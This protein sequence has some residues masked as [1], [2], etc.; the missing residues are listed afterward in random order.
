M[1]IIREGFC[2]HHREARRRAG[3]GGERF[4]V[5]SCKTLRADFAQ[6]CRGRRSCEGENAADDRCREFVLVAHAFLGKD[7]F[8]SKLYS[9][10]SMRRN[11]RF[12]YCRTGF[13][14]GGHAAYQDR[15]FLKLH[16]ESVGMPSCFL[17]PI[18]PPVH[19]HSSNL[20]AQWASVS[21][22]RFHSL[23]VNRR[24]SAHGCCALSHKQ[25]SDLGLQRSGCC[26]QQQRQ[27]SA[28]PP[29]GFF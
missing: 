11:Q 19:A 12:P 28:L 16:G 7:L 23:S 17:R 27:Y 25:S 26:G 2:R 21:S 8:N 10:S 15:A 20:S 24:R 14:C 4:K 13:T 18:H 22:Y 1:R 9:N 5:R 3:K 6:R 29:R